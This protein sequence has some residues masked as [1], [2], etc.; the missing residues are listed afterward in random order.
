MGAGEREQSAPF[1]FALS[2]CSFTAADE[3]YPQKGKTSLTESTICMCCPSKALEITGVVEAEY[4]GLLKIFNRWF[5]HRRTSRSDEKWVV[6]D[7]RTLTFSTEE[8]RRASKKLYNIIEADAVDYDAS[9]HKN[10]FIWDDDDTWDA[11]Y[12]SDDEEED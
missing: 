2:L 1:Q 9:K 7:A 12:L 10:C 8:D 5:H 6:F 3:P 11:C 4:Y